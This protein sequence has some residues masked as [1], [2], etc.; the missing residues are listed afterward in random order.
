M[1]DALLFRRAVL[2]QLEAASPASL[3]VETVSAG[4]KL[5]GFDFSEREFSAALEYLVEK[6]YALFSRS[7]L[8]AS[9]VRVKLSAFGR[10]YLESGRF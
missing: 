3:P 6:N 9:H 4:L 10:D 5:A 2:A 8:S 1:T 7:E